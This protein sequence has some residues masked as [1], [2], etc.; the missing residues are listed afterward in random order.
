MSYPSDISQNHTVLV[1][2]SERPA[3]V[4]LAQASLLTVDEAAGRLRVGRTTM[5][6]LLSTGKVA[7]IQI[8]R[9]RRIEPRALDDFLEGRR[10]ARRG[11]GRSGLRRFSRPR[12]NQL[13]EPARKIRRAL[14]S[15]AGIDLKR[16][17]DRGMAQVRLN[18]LGGRPGVDEQG[19]TH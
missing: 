10:I 14:G 13:V 11:S 2:A 16:R 4:H 8:G 12:G 5:Y 6:Q 7:S 15:H 17:L 9:L 1:P 19:S 18:V 3:G